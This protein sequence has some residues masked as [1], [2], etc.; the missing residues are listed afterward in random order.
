[1]KLTGT[2]PERPG[3]LHVTP[4]LDL[5]L[6]VV[7][8]F[9]VGPSLVLQSGVTVDL[10]PSRFQMERY[11]DTLVVTLGAGQVEGKIHLGRVSVGFEELEEILEAKRA[12]G[13]A[14]R[15]MVLL[16]TAAGIPVREERRVAEMILAKGYRLALVGRP[17]QT[18]PGAADSQPEPR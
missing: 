11:E 16:Q 14:A 3:F 5:F 12:D 15:A 18:T 6:L 7:L 1:M 8:F 4:V 9:M 17:E 2:L 10:P 13:T